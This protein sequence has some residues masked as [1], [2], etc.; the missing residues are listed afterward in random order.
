MSRDGKKVLSFG[1][2]YAE[3]II[4]GKS[5]NITDKISDSDFEL[6]KMRFNQ[7]DTVYPNATQSDR[8]I[9]M[10]EL[11]HKAHLGYAPSDLSRGYANINKDGNQWKRTIEKIGFGNFD[12]SS[13]MGNINEKLKIEYAKHLQAKKDGEI[14]FADSLQKTSTGTN[15]FMDSPFTYPLYGGSSGIVLAQLLPM[16]ELRTARKA[17][18]SNFSNMMFV[19]SLLFRYIVRKA[20][21]QDSAGFQGMG[22]PVKEGYIGTEYGFELGF[23]N[24]DCFKY[25]FHSALT[26]EM[27]KTMANQY[28]MVS[29]L[30]A[31][32]IGGMSILKDAVMGMQLWEAVHSGYLYRW[33]TNTGT[34]VKNLMEIAGGKVQVLLTNAP[35]FHCFVDWTGTGLTNHKLMIPSVTTTEEN[36]YDSATAEPTAKTTD[37]ILDI[38]IRYGI[39]K[40]MDNNGNEPPT[41][42]CIPSTLWADFINDD[43]LIN[44][45]TRI[46]KIPHMQNTMGYC[47]TLSLPIIPDVN[48][49]RYVYNAG[50]V[51]SQLPDVASDDSTPKTLHPIFIL[52]KNPLVDGTFMPPTVWLDEGFTAA[53]VGPAGSS[54][55]VLRRDGTKVITVS[56]IGFSDVQDVYK[57]FILDFYIS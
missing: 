20:R 36:E 56:E 21:L 53:D 22:T 35:L 26:Y 37:E 24:G 9:F 44:S 51:N 29:S 45:N 3:K 33:N 49:W 25:V 52:G 8:R 38:L 54:Y 42:I 47:G 19:D 16:V 31:D 43:R 1:N 50:A 4:A 41:D 7:F 17:F 10:W 48:I 57:A 23:Q 28:P 11:L 27:I 12:P 15:P 39:P 5:G 46:T 55:P 34:W 40:Y 2:G 13:H 18:W 30:I 14:S 6:I 32:M